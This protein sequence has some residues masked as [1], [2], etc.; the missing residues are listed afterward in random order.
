MKEEIQIR[1]IRQSG[2]DNISELKENVIDDGTR[3]FICLVIFTLHYQTNEIII[4][5]S[6]LINTFNINHSAL[7]S[8]HIQWRADQQQCGRSLIRRHFL[9]DHCS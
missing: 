8:N 3:L 7:I 2:L 9:L 6:T 4:L 1:L 5:F